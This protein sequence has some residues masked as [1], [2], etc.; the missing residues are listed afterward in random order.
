MPVAGLDLGTDVQRRLGSWLALAV[1]AGGFVLIGGGN[2]DLGPLEARIGLSAAERFGPFGQ[3][4]GGWEPGIWPGQVAPSAL[5]AWGEAWYYPTAATVRWP[6]AIAGVLAGLLLARHAGRTLGRGATFWVGLAW[7]G[8]LALIDRSAGAGLDLVAGLTVVGALNRLLGRGSDLWA[9]V[10]TALAFLGG[11][12]PPVAL[13]VLATIVIGRREAGL[14]ARL[15]VPPLLAALFWSAWALSAAKADAW[16]TALTLPLTQRSAW[17]LPFGVLALALPWGPFAALAASASVRE[18]WPAPGR[19]LVLGWLQVAGACVLMGTVVPGL[20]SAA[21][22]PALAGLAVAAGAGLDR[23]W[24]GTVARS[25]R[26]AFLTLM[27]VVVGLWVILAVAGGVY[28]GWTVPYYRGMAAVLVVLAAPAFLLAVAAV[29]RAQARQ[30]LLALILVAVCLKL[31]HWGIYVPEWNYRFSQG[32]WGRAIGQWILPRWPIYTSHAWPADLALAIARPL[33]Q[34]S[35]PRMLPHQ[36]KIEPK[37][38]LL[39]DTEF[40]NWPQGAPAL[41]TVARFQDERGRTRILAR[42][43]GNASWYHL[44]R[45][46]GEE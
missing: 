46:R 24:A 44:S 29:E 33:R 30:G 43:P 32:P 19:A 15:L 28:V 27:A 6:S 41:T 31:G 8:S 14:S 12:W 9:G 25:A 21:R 42:T 22:L 26:N 3:M 11:G 38:V 2:L 13:I 34:F 35:D 20:A 39:L 4:Y 45:L 37:F 23:L 36:S 17:L 16:A 40:E 5:W 18:R 1:L 10:W 7:F